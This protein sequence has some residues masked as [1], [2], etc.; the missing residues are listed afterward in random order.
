MHA[1]QEQIETRRLVLV[2]MST[3][4]AR[5]IL[6]GDLSVV[7]HA[8]GWPHAD[9]LD[10]VCMAVDE[11]AA[12]PVWL[13]T[14]DGRVIGDCGTVGHV[15]EAGDIDIGQSSMNYLARATLARTLE[16]QGGR[17][18]VAGITVPVRGFRPVCRSKVHAGFW[19]AGE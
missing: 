4:A 14:L 19:R 6:S 9:T 3:D 18:N 10:A 7:A 2:P 1:L 11:D 8:E 15:D 13:V 5:A 12:W 16:G 17:D